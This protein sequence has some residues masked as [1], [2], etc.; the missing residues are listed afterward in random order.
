VRPQTRCLL[1]H[2][3]GSTPEFVE[4][5]FGP[6]M[7]AR[8]W[9]LIAPDVRGADMAEMVAVIAERAPGPEDLIGGVSLGAHA[10]AMYAGTNDYVGSLLAV[11]PAWIGFPGPVA[12]LTASTADAIEATS[13]AEVLREIAHSAPDDDW[14]L[15]EL[16]RAWLSMSAQRLVAALR[17]AAEQP[18]PGPPT[19]RRITARTHIVALR[20]DPTHPESVATTWHGCIAGS[21]LT[22]LPRDLQGGPP[23]RL[24]DHLLQIN[25]SL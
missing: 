1:L 24:V 22:V 12:A 5:A 25:G 2:G 21:S 14:I 13:T 23:S 16:R 6:A 20:D 18:A 17:T 11:M 19:L 8:G 10:A 4:R 15:A 7:A 3:A 9:Q